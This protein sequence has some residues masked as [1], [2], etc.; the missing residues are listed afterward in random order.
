MTCVCETPVLLDCECAVCSSDCV[1]VEGSGNTGPLVFS[2]TLDPDEDNILSC[3]ASG[4]LAILPAT[5]L[6][7]PTCK[8]FHNTTQSIPANFGTRVSFNS[9]TYD[10]DGMHSGGDPERITFNTAGLYS[11]VFSGAFAAGAASDGDRAAHI[12]KNGTEI[13]AGS[14][15]FAMVS[16]SLDNGLNVV[17]QEVFEVGDYVEVLVKQDSA[18][19]KNLQANPLLAVRFRRSVPT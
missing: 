11:V 14:S 3:S 1:A 15:R 10:N 17:A 16:T 12:R 5:I 13:L 4:L 18:G 9:E 7:P 6:V 2:P 8:V 19:A